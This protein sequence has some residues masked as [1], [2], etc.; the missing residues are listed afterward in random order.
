MSA[1][2]ELLESLR[3]YH[4]DNTRLLHELQAKEQQLTLL[5][6]HTQEC[7][8]RIKEL[9]TENSG[10]KREMQDLREAPSALDEHLR[11]E[12]A[13]LQHQ[14]RSAQ[15]APPPEELIQAIAQLRQENAA[16]TEQLGKQSEVVQSMLIS[17][18]GTSGRPSTPTA[19]VSPV[20]GNGLSSNDLLLLVN[21]NEENEVLSAQV[22]A[23][24]QQLHQRP[25]GDITPSS[26]SLSPVTDSSQAA[27]MVSVKDG[28]VFVRDG[29]HDITMV[30]YLRTAA[31]RCA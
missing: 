10:L 17:S 2:A 31:A 3:E 11:Q 22:S 24:Q 30:E 1:E 21:L 6:H 26:S 25:R 13:A 7:D 20:S 27:V 28:R 29:E 19:A 23:L 4:S 14:L 15:K 12:I 18:L 16:L 9:E 8:A 5:F